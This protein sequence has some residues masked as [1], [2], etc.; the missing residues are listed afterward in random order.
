MEEKKRTE[1][2]LVSVIICVHNVGSLLREALNSVI[3]QTYKEIEIIIIDD[4]STDGS[5]E[6]IKDIVDSRI[7]VVRQE[8][9]R[10]P[11]ALNRALSLIKG[12]FYTQQDADDVS[13]PQRIEKQVECMMK[14][15]KLAAVYTGHDMIIGKWKHVAPCFDSYSPEE[16]FERIGKINAVA[17]DPT[18]L[19]RVDIVKDILYNV[20]YPLSEGFDYML[21][22]G[23]K[24]P[25]MLLEKCLYTYRIRWDSATR[26]RNPLVRMQMVWDVKS[27]ACKRRGLDPQTYL[28]SRPGVATKLT[29]RDYDND[30]A[31]DFILSVKSCIKNGM[32]YKAIE[33]G[34]ICASMHPLDGHYLKALIYALCPA[35]I[36]KRR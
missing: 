11:T 31:S 34:I 3:S 19:F 27:D 9:R 14:F 18:G 8:N 25:I 6:S 10:K 1:N 36:I 2:P 28:G 30:L 32:R 20:D 7:V 33:A 21:R 5:M 13:Y 16:A 4:G 15:P 23:E 29:N 12:E 35:W 24:L 26:E 22:V 17:L